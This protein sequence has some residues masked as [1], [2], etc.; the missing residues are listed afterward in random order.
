MEILYAWET[1]SEFDFLLW[2]TLSE[3]P[4]VMMV[5]PDWPLDEN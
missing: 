4:G 2:I 3:A 5:N 1:I